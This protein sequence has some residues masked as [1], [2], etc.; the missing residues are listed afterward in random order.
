MSKADLAAHRGWFKQFAS[1]VL[2]KLQRELDET[3]WVKPVGRSVQIVD[4]NSGGWAAHLGSVRGD[5]GSQLQ[6]WF[7]FWTGAAQRKVA[8]SYSNSA[9]KRIVQI[10][11][12]GV[13]GLGVA[14]RFKDAYGASEQADG[15][16]VMNPPLPAGLFGKPLVEIT[17]RNG[18]R[19]FL[20]V[21]EAQQPRV[22]ESP[23]RALVDRASQFLVEA[24]L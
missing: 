4:T 22:T 19:N 10:A 15:V 9:E 7:D 2:D 23:S 20:A 16:N 12:I 1:L 6:L 17:S 13:G 18:F 11:D 24:A 3:A 5:R 8:Y 14:R 21:Y